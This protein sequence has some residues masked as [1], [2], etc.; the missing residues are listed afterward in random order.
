MERDMLGVFPAQEMKKFVEKFVD[1][2][3]GLV[4]V[5]AMP[6]FVVSIPTQETNVCVMSMIIFCSVS[7]CNLSII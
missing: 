6:G 2:P 7:G 4:L 5:T 1:W 3:V